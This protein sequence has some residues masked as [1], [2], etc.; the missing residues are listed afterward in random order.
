MEDI[1]KRRIKVAEYYSASGYGRGINKRNV[2]LIDG[3]Y[4]A[5]HPKYAEQQYSPLNG[6]FKGYIKVNK[7][8]TYNT[9]H[10]LGVL[11]EHQLVM[12]K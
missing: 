4:Y 3:Y 10:A 8:S 9:F 2:Y 11:E 5:Y 7:C 6:E 12:D 1:K